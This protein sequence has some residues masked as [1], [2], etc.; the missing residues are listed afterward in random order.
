MSEYKPR[1]VRMKSL[2][3]LVRGKII[4]V[5][6]ASDDGE[7]YRYKVLPDGPELGGWYDFGE[8]LMVVDGPT[9]HENLLKVAPTLFEEITTPIEVDR[10]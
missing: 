4:K 1:Y 7:Y 3:E 9:V 5:I 2:K 8:I 10:E 6:H